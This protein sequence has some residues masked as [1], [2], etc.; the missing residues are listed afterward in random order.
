MSACSGERPLGFWLAGVCALLRRAWIHVCSCGP[1]P[2]RWLDGPRALL[3][4]C[5]APL[6]DLMPRSVRQAGCFFGRLM[7]STTLPVWSASEGYV[8]ADGLREFHRD[9][10]LD[11][12]ES[13]LNS[14]IPCSRPLLWPFKLHRVDRP[15][16]APGSQ[17]AL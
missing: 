7:A 9:L 8:P 15:G 16:L 3:H 12:A 6:R 4:A 14:W 2:M 11:L 10:E 1:A 5:P 13:D 17:A